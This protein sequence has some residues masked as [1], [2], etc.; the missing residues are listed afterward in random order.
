MNPLFPDQSPAELPVFSWAGWYNRHRLK[1]Y[2]ALVFLIYS[3]WAAYMTH[4]GSWGL[5]RDYWPATLTMVLGSFVAGATAEGGGA[6]AYPVFTKVLYIASQDARTFS[7]MIQSFG[8]GMAS[9]FI[10]TRKIRILPKVIIWVSLGGALGQVLGAYWLVIPNPYPKVLF[11][12]VTTTFGCAL[13]LSTYI[14]KWRPL[15][16][17]PGWGPGYRLF[18]TALGIFGGVFA[19]QVGTGID[20]ITFMVLTLAFGVDEKVSTP[21]TVIIM[22][23]NSW[24]GFFLHGVVS[25]D[26]G[27]MWNYWLVAVEVVIIGAPLGAYLTSMARRHTVINFILALIS[28]E[29][30][31]TLLLVPFRTQAEIIVTLSA[32]TVFATAFWL[33]LRYR[34]RLKMEAVPA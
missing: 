8:M 24:V 13:F 17:L 32:V 21:S 10:L 11:T 7:L 29:L 3:I 28:L 2:P 23:L 22:A 27:Q 14:L 30:V 6:V 33:M 16:G 12:F 15:P 34:S 19:A 26:I 4:S 1:I 20:V 5:F 9:V 31:T 25:K 18:F